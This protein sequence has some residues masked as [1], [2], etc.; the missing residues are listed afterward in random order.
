MP[1]MSWRARLFRVAT[2]ALMTGCSTATV[3]GYVADQGREIEVQVASRELLTPAAAP[4]VAPRSDG[5]PTDTDR[6]LGLRWRF[7]GGSPSPGIALGPDGAVYVPTHEGHVHSLSAD[8]SFRW[9]FNCHAPP[10]GAAVTPAGLLLVGT[11]AGMLHAI[12]PGGTGLWAYRAPYPLLTP[13]AVDAAGTAYFGDRSQNVVAVSAYGGARWRAPLEGTI[14]AGPVLLPDGKVV[15]GTDRAELLWIEGVLRRRRVA[16]PGT[17]VQSPRVLTDG[18][19]LVLTDGVLLGVRDGEELW[20][21][22]GV[23][24]MAATPRGYVTLGEGELCRHLEAGEPRCTPFD[25]VASASPA[26]GPQGRLFVPTPEG[27]LV[28]VSPDGST[29][30]TVLVAR[31]ALWEPVVDEARGQ[32]LASAGD[33]VVGAVALVVDGRN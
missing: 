27:E 8:G 13:L 28:V 29:E 17:P 7:R 22:S 25:R 30:R 20:R 14:T 24:A 2:T 3:P 11:T 6:G 9:S 26:L 21:R 4:V 33:G 1:G 23:Q 32:V 5:P 19:L 12:L 18:T 10:T 31:A 15:V 16:L